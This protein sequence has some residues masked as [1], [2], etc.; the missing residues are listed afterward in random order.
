MSI[1]A[2]QTSHN[3][4]IMEYSTPLDNPKIVEWVAEQ[5]A[6]TGSYETY[7]FLVTTCDFFQSELGGG[8]S[9]EENSWYQKFVDENGGEYN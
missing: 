7:I 8:S 5:K 6:G 2:G 4:Y 1:T 9:G 3:G